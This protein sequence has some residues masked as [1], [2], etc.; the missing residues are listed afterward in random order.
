MAQPTPKA[1]FVAG[2]TRRIDLNRRAVQTEF[3]PL[4]EDDLSWRRD[5]R[6]WSVLQCVDHLNRTHDYYVQ[7]I[8][9]AI[10]R[11]V[12]ARAGADV[13]APTWMARAFMGFAFNPLVSIPT[14]SELAPEDAPSAGALNEFITR[15]STVRQLLDAVADLDLTHTPVPL[16]AGVRF[17][18]GDCLTMLVR[19]D[20][21]HIR[22]ARAV[23]DALTATEAVG[24]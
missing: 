6:T 15:Q 10:P 4:P 21:H 19:H 22:Q 13:Y 3:L 23:L 16:Q 24:G 7:R 8:D 5:D 2:L 11:A 20:G 17:N 1:S 9:A 14:L 18:L 12:P